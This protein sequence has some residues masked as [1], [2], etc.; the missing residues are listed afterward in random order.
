MDLAASAVLPS[1]REAVELYVPS[2]EDCGESAAAE[3]RVAKQLNYLEKRRRRDG[4]IH[5][6]PTKP[7]AWCTIKSAASRVIRGSARD[8]VASCGAIDEGSAPSRCP[9]H[10]GR[11]RETGRRATAEIAIS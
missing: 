10:R 2:T 5:R 7:S 1:A 4:D 6:T 8:L 3:R 9:D 11:G